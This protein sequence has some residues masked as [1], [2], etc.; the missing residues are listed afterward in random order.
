MKTFK[1]CTAILICLLCLA[2]CGQERLPA[3]EK[4]SEEETSPTETTESFAVGWKADGF[5]AVGEL[6]E[7]QSLWAAE[8]MEWKHTD[9]SEN[10]LMRRIYSPQVLGDR[11]YQLRDITDSGDGR[12]YL[13]EVYDTS[14]MQA[15]ATEI[16]GERLGLDGGFIADMNV[17]EQGMY[18]FLLL[19]YEQDESKDTD[20]FQLLHAD[21][22]YTDL[23][24]DME[25]VD[26]L[27][28]IQENGQNDIYQQCFCDAFG[29]IYLRGILGAFP[30]RQLFILDHSGS[31][32]M[33]QSI[34]EDDEIMSPFRMPGGELIFPV[35]NH[36]E[37]TSRLV[38]FDPEEKRMRVLA[39]L[40]K[41]TIDQVYGVQGTDLYYE[42]NKG[43]IKWELMSGDRVLVF[44]FEENSVSRIYDTMLVFR[45]GQ[46]PVLRMY[47]EVNG[48]EEDWLV[49]LSGQK[50]EEAE[51]IQ[52]VGLSGDSA[53]VRDC[54]AMASRRNPGL[55]FSYKTCSEREREA[56]RTRILTELTAG[57][58]PDILYVSLAD[59]RSLQSMGALAELDSFLT[60]E[61]KN[62]LLP[63]VI[64]LG[65]VDGTFV[66][67]APD[68]NLESMV[69]LHSIWEQD[70]WRLEDIAGL[71][72]TGDFTG[73]FCQG[74]MPFA[75]QALLRF[76]TMFGL[77]ES[78]LIDWETRESHFDSDLFIKLLEL[79]KTYGN[80]SPFEADT[81]LGVGGCPG[82]IMGP[83]I[84][85]FNSLYEQY[86]D[87]YHF[88]GMPTRGSSGSYLSSSG[89]LVVNRNTAD[90]DAV[91]AYLSCLLENEIQYPD[92]LNRD[93][94][95]LKVSLDETTTIEFEG[96]TRSFWKDSRLQ[97]KEDGTTTLHDYKEFL[98]SCIPRPESYDDII[99]LVW[100]ESQS[101]I[102]GDK[103]AREVAR[104]IDSRIQLYLDEGNGDF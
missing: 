61:M 89:V 1:T 39:A 47:A 7:E 97:I 33:E 94:S 59:M 88:V 69:T 28:A 5:A 83:D 25:K 11:I 2:G 44:S 56:F 36:A 68:I 51:A 42:S 50:P 85:S 100:E 34:G 76:L 63:G 92:R 21:I 6:K 62:Q 3:G 45:D 32:L 104:I 52:I 24:E 17:M 86:G 60:A 96:E 77:Q 87:E 90:P 99:S 95:I 48:G 4:I 79:A 8:Y 23:K 41:E 70:T 72:D 49:S 18:A 66:G 9:G 84:E 38:W 55:S 78:A 14:T 64:E 26:I 31:L 71:L 43:I 22:V 29:N 67:I 46:M 54:V 65:S 101:Y 102:A 35:N 73:I 74:T 58:G 57:E 16:E 30:S 27:S 81:W 13:L 40:E 12:R 82:M 19:K 10:G 37:K 80:P 98:E 15:N 75:P 20:K 93:C 103:S 53:N 91:S